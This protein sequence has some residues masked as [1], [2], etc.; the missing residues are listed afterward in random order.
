MAVLRIIAWILVAL[1]LLLL[2]ADAISTL[3]S[4]SGPVVRTTAEILGLIGIP[5]I[6]V[7]N[8]GIA[9][10]A[11]WLLE[12]P[13]WAIFGIIGVIMTLIFRPIN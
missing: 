11:K 4:D 3:E 7:E 8:G 12:A 1:A 6:D 5:P 9:G 10:A 2:G 13:L